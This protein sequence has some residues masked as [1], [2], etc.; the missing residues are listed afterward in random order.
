MRGRRLISASWFVLVLGSSGIIRA[1]PA[2]GSYEGNIAPD[3]ARPK[4]IAGGRRKG[5]YPSLIEGSTVR[6][7]LL[8]QKDGA[9]A[10]IMMHLKPPPLTNISY[11]VEVRFRITKHS[12]GWYKHPLWLLVSKKKAGHH[13]LQ[14]GYGYAPDRWEDGYVSATLKLD[15]EYH[16][17][18]KDKA[19]VSGDWVTVRWVVV[20]RTV[21]QML[22]V[23]L[24]GTNIQEVTT[25]QRSVYDREGIYVCSADLDDAWAIDYIRWKNEALGIREPLTRPLSAEEKA[26]RMEAMY[27]RKLRELVE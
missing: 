11:T 19:V 21:D 20:D 1:E 5:E 26:E 16:V 24:N 12:R 3:E 2:D 10:D 22:S 6:D 25:R 23:F 13:F 17:A 8:I 27:L 18:V 14:A 7:G 4:W 15:E 9:P